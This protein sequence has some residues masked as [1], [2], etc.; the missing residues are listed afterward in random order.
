M[1]VSTDRR[2]A[3]TAD[4]AALVA[5][6]ALLQTNYS[7]LATKNVKEYTFNSGDGSQAA[8]RV[9]LSELRKEIKEVRAEIDAIDLELNQMCVVRMQ[10][11][12]W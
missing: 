10:S 2:T 4:R 11:S 5:T 8:K 1:T 3:L 12:R 7:E 9:T 6:L